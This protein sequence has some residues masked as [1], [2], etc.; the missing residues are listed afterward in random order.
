MKIQKK[1]FGLTRHNNKA[2]LF[3]LSN[4]NGMTVKITNYGGIITGIFIPD[5]NGK[6]EN[7]V[8]G[9]DR[10]DDYVSEKY[11]DDG[12]YFGAIIGRVTNRIAG[13]RFTIDGTE[14]RI[15]SK[16]QLYSHHGGI[17]GF[18]KKLW[19]A[20]TKSGGHEVS[21]VLRY[22]S[23]DMEEGYPGN[24]TV[25]VT[26]TLNNDN[27]LI[28]DYAARTD[29]KTHVNLT[30]H[31]YFNLTACREDVLNHELIIHAD[32]YTE[33]DENFIPTGKLLPVKGTPLD[34]TEKHLIGERIRLQ[35]HGNGYDHN[36]VL[37]DYHGQI[38]KAAEVTEAAS[39]RK[40]E[41]Y[42]TE[43][44]MQL[45]TGN[46]LNGTFRNRDIIF[47][48]RMGVCFE[49]QHFPDSPNHPGFPSTLLAPGEIF[50]SETVFRFSW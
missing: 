33:T 44:G 22:L 50:H 6:A 26:Y 49:A 18:D 27:A 31:A 3:T 8:L 48:K 20:E 4:D 30:N 2:Y 40:L 1:I 43:P 41:V 24:L 10:L 45:Y 21:L 42:T 46:Y 29:K 32:Q 9:F 14:Y 5:K 28:I 15:R 39:G 25:T 12:P 23:R 17:E 34:F 16:N 37:N 38:R 47:S 7:V 13:G 35:K 11:I 19:E 36:Y